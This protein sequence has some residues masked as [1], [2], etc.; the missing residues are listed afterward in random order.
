MLSLIVSP[1]KFVIQCI[2]TTLS[3]QLFTR[4]QDPIFHLHS[5]NPSKSNNLAWAL[6]AV[7]SVSIGV[8]GYII[9]QPNTKTFYLG[10]ILWWAF[11]PL[12]LLLTG[13]LPFALRSWKTYFAAIWIP[14]L[15]LWRADQYALRKDT[16]HIAV[17][18]HAERDRI[19]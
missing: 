9:G 19:S 2:M 18:S 4:W 16:W 7:V 15:Y 5:S 14:T 12:S 13:T 3:T 11:V 1:F 17:S 6:T 10:S 8:C